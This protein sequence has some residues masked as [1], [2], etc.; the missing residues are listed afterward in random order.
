MDRLRIWTVGLALLLKAGAQA[1]SGE[2]AWDDMPRWGAE[3]LAYI[4]LGSARIYVAPEPIKGYSTFHARPCR[5]GAAYRFHDGFQATFAFERATIRSGGLQNNVID[6]EWTSGEWFSTTYQAYHADMTTIEHQVNALCLGIAARSSPVALGKVACRVEMRAGL[7][8]LQAVAGFGTYHT[9]GVHHIGLFSSSV[10]DVV[11]GE[12]AVNTWD[13]RREAGRQVAMGLSADG[14]F[15]LY[16]H[17][18]RRFALIL[19]ELQ[20][21]TPM[22]KPSFGAIDAGDVRFAPHKLVLGYGALGVGIV[23]QWQSCGAGYSG[24]GSWGHSPTSKSTVKSR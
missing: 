7:R 12:Q 19:P 17:W 22:V 24:A 14:A 9:S 6:D 15:R 8:I 10:W 3:V 4:P 18:G 1:Q 11:D 23:L 2:A 20:F 5:I 13:Q 21:S 16:V